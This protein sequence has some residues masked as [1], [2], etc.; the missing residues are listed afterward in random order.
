M[1]GYTQRKRQSGVADN[2]CD[3]SGA[4]FEYTLE[5]EDGRTG[6]YKLVGHFIWYSAQEACK[7]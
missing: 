6:M 5:T 3:C 7:D 2:I 4:S 1:Q